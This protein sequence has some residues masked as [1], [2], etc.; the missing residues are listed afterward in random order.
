M[1]SAVV[2]DAEMDSPS[3][4]NPLMEVAMMGACLEN[5]TDY[6]SIRGKVRITNL[7]NSF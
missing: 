2:M 4:V 5:E 3:K 1:S 6:S 7:P